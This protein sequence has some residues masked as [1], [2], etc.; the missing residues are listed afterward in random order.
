MN[1]TIRDKSFDTAT[2]IESGYAHGFEKREVRH[3]RFHMTPLS[4]GGEYEAATFVE[5]GKRKER[6]VGLQRLVVIRGWEH[7]PLELFTEERSSSYTVLSAKYDSFS[8]EL[9]EYLDTYLAA[10]APG[11]LIVD[12]RL[13]LQRDVRLSRQPTKETGQPSD[14]GDDIGDTSADSQPEPNFLEGAVETVVLDRYERDPEAR[15]ACLRHYGFECRVCEIAMSDVYGDLGS[16]FI[17]VHHRVPLGDVRAEHDVDPIRDLIPVCPNCH[18]MLHRRNPPM[19]VE[20]LAAIVRAR[21]L[22]AAKAGA[23]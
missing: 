16:G 21:R 12:Q 15:R 9:D 10:L 17:H 11:L 7:P 3:I 19:K 22:S 1:E 14:P 6:T 13:R 5:R 20:D 8:E 2:V 18:S 4:T 23:N